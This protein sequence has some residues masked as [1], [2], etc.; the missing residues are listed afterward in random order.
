MVAP[1]HLFLEAG[2]TVAVALIV[3]KAIRGRRRP[4]PFALGVD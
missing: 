1:A 4:I 3:A 2:S